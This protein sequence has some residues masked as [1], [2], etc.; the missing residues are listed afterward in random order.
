LGPCKGIT[1]LLPVS[2]LGHS[3]LIPALIGGSWQNLV[4][5]TVSADSKG[6]PYLS[7][8][9]ALDVAT[10]VALVVLYRS[11][12]VRIV[13]AS[14]CSLRARRID[15]PTGR[16]AWL[17]VMATIPVARIGLVLES[18]LRIL[19]GEPVVAAAFL[20]VNGLILLAGEPLRAAAEG[21]PSRVLPPESEL[22]VDPLGGR[23]WRLLW[24]L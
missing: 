16:L 17:L 9:V 11:N 22:S 12:R 15:T 4:T 20:R 8:V 3:V 7:F 18:P 1:E 23:P 2:S 5:Q 21:A 13:A 6:S 10:A 24:G 19:C 14:V